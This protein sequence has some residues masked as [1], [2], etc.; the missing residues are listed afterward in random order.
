[1]LYLYTPEFSLA[2]VE[3]HPRSSLAL[4]SAFCKLYPFPPP[5]L[6]NTLHGKYPSNKSCNSCAWKPLGSQDGIIWAS[7][8]DIPH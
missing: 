7:Q 6:V 3:T 1:M 4:G 8:D 5:A 2:A